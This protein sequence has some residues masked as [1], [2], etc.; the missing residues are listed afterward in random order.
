MDDQLFQPLTLGD[1]ELSHRIVLSPLTR[2]R[3]IDNVPNALM[4]EYYTQ[5]AAGGLLI[6][7]GTA[8]HPNGLGYPRIPGIYSDAQV[9]GWRKVTD[10]VHAAGGRIFVQLMHVGRIGHP[11]NLPEG[12]ELVA[13]S[14]VAAPG[15]MYTD[16]AGPQPHPVP[17]E[18][19]EDDVQVALDGYVHAARQAIAAGFDGIELHGA[20][21]YL[22]DQFLHPNT[23]L[24]TDAWGGSPEAR[25]RFAIEAARRTAE[26]IGASKVGIRLS[27]F[28][29]FNGIQPF[30]E[31]PAQYA[32]LAGELGKLGLAYVHLVDHSAMGAPEVPWEVKTAIR[33]AFGGP[34]I[35][36]GGYDRAR[37]EADLQA[38]RGEL[39]A[40]G[41]PYLANP[42][43]VHRLRNDL[44]LNDPRPDL[45]Y[46]PGPEGYT[47]YPTASEG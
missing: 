27:P 4:A 31:L 30:D 24:R 20:N 2:S 33:E 21:G 17:R 10:S 26:A 14:A 23:N 18:M 46:T 13:P 36:S 42:D 37:A 11:H 12:A 32:S 28:G 45:F 1:L 41:R 39:V 38:G 43:L 15:E 47:D 8:P 25:N 3:A 40:F 6:T 9:D 44:P 35:L 16:A 29:V 5:R 34:I 19:T 22:I 7:E